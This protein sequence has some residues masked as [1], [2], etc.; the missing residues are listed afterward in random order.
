MNLLSNG[1]LMRKTGSRRRTELAEGSAS[2][3][4]F[5]AE[6]ITRSRPVRHK[7]NTTNLPVSQLCDNNY[8]KSSPVGVAG[9]GVPHAAGFGGSAGT[10][11]RLLREHRARVSMRGEV[12][13]SGARSRLAEGRSHRLYV[14]WMR[15][16]P[17]PHRFL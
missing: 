12:D 6:F 11:Y 16:E 5:S 2:Q 15:K 8:A 13:P 9:Q 17:L 7:S 10:L 14:R 1:L 4:G 3:C